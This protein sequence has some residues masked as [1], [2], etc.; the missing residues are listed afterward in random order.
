[1]LSATW[2][3]LIQG[4][5]ASAGSVLI[6]FD[7]GWYNY[8]SYI[9]R[10]GW[11]LTVQILK[12]EYSKITVNTM[13]ADGLAPCIAS[14]SA[15]VVLT[16]QHEAVIV[17]NEEQFQLPTPSQHQLIEAEWRIYASV[18]WTI[19]G[20]DNGLLLGRHQ[21]IISSNAG[22]LLIGPLRTNFS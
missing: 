3:L 12:Q 7:P 22:I 11:Y 16:M 15:D 14:T 19:I 2:L 10:L 6:Y 9:W 5:R 21:A 20:S 17:F 18:N 8:L 4:S 1:M 13:A